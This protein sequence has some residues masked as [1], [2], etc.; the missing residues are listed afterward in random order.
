MTIQTPVPG[1]TPPSDEARAAPDKAFAAA[2]RIANIPTLLMVLVQLTGD[3]SWLDAPYRPRRGR[4]L[5]DNDDG[6]LAHDI[7]ARIRDAALAAVL[8]WRDGRPVA[9][10]A[11]SDDLLVR[12]LSVAM[13]EPVPAAYGEII[14]SGLGLKPHRLDTV[15]D[16]TAPSAVPAGFHAVIIGAGVSGICAAIRLRARGIRVTIVEKGHDFGGTWRENRY[17]GAGV[18]TPNHIYS[19]SFAQH[20]WPQYFALQGELFAYFKGVAERFALRTCARFDTTVQAARWDAAACRWAVTTRGDDGRTDILAADIVISAVGVLN[21]PLVPA[22]PGLDGFSGPCFHTARWPEGLDLAG[23]R[24]AIVGNGASAMQ[25]APAIAGQV[26]HLTILARSKQWAAP[27][28]QFRKPVPDPVRFLLRSLPL[29]QAW[30][31]QRLAWTFNDRIHG[32][33]QKDPDWPHPERALNAVN[34][35]HRRAFTAYI[36]DELAERPD[37]V[38]KVLPDYPPFGKRMLLDNGW[39]RT[40]ARDNVSLVTERLAEVRGSTLIAGDGSR[41]QADVLVMA[42][43]FRASEFLASFEVFGRDGRRLAEVWDGDDARAYLGT[44]IPGFPNLFTLLGPNVGLGHG[45][46]II[47]AVELQTDYL[48]SAL[49]RMFA[50]KA[51]TIEVRADVHDRYNQQ[52][53]VHHDRMIWTHQGTDNWYRNSRGRVVAITPWRNDDFWRMTRA[54]DPADY[55]FGG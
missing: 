17:P 32:S 43:G 47:A 20:D 38:D 15:I 16:D 21:T 6:G 44:T 50:C 10:P 7:Q 8:A 52:V 55:L 2:I 11:P 1:I 41:H 14:A 51:R 28:P 33:L 5:D 34:D 31:R 48:I 9:I 3:P 19:F 29:Y 18:D 30:Y 22:I 25:V 35:G 12:M 37:L 27:F 45:G 53:D 49:E 23:Q 54:V 24:V 39:Y 4:G 46:S 26:A 36:R 42:T 13:A 40:I